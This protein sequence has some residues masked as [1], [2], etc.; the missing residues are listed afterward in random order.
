LSSRCR[1]NLPRGTQVVSYR[2]ISQDG[3]PVAG[4]MVFSIGAATTTAGNVG[5]D[6]KPDRS[7]P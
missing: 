3:H 2:V 5:A 1:K 7:T 4:A 6:N